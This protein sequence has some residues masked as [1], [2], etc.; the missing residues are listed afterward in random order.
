MSEQ[1]S[2]PSDL[3]AVAWVH[4][5]LRRTLEAAHKALRRFSREVEAVDGLRLDEF[6]GVDPRRDGCRM[7]RRQ[8][9]IR[10]AMGQIGDESLGSRIEAGDVVRHGLLPMIQF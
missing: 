5:E 4:D 10:P 8:F 7:A 1:M 9:K 2:D 6:G 3:S